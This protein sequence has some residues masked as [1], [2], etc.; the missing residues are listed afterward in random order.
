MRLTALWTLPALL[1][2]AAL[3]AA[4]A[5]GSAALAAEP[6]HGQLLAS[7]E[8]APMTSDSELIREHER[9]ASFA[10]EQVRRMNATIIGGRHG[11]QVS[12]GRDGLYRASYKAIDGDA[13]VCHVSR[14][15]HDPRYFVGVLI[16]KEL[17]LESV[18]QTAEACR[19]GEF[20]PVAQKSQQVIYSSRRGGGWN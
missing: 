5:S 19:Q 11:M 2:C 3:A 14:A 8:A 4:T 20:A 17:V 12:K 15:Q 1:V 7:A 6:V 10:R 16:Y 18:A 13:V 9:F